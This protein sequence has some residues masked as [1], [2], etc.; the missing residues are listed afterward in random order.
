MVGTYTESLTSVSA[1]WLNR[2]ITG[3]LAMAREIPA[4]AILQ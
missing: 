1:P 2:T 4:P 3:L